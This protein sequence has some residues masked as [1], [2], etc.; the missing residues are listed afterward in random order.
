MPPAG[1][2]EGCAES[3][4][5]L[6]RFYRF[7]S[8]PLAVAQ[9]RRPE[10]PKR[11][12]DAGQPDGQ[13]HAAGHVCPAEHGREHLR[14]GPDRAGRHAQ[15][16]KPRWK[17]PGIRRESDRMPRVCGTRSRPSLRAIRTS[18]PAAKGAR[19]AAVAAAAYL[20]SSRTIASDP[21][22][23]VRHANDTAE[24]HRLGRHR[25][26]AG[27]DGHPRRDR[28][29]V[30]RWRCI[31]G[32]RGAVRC[33]A[34]SRLRVPVPVTISFGRDQRRCTHERENAIEICRSPEDVFGYL[35]RHRQGG[36]VEPEDQAGRE[37]H[38]GPG[39]GLPGHG[40]NQTPAQ[41]VTRPAVAVD[42]A[43]DAR[44]RR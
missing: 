8:L 42:A 2:R 10:R 35:T 29:S 43:N 34:V 21:S 26:S 15:P 19:S 11:K 36:R 9:C 37:A 3:S 20:P 31:S 39:T 16:R 13:Q 22:P 5:R 41:G 27:V 4:L 38:A 14:D 6:R 25:E 40:Q 33:S 17:R 12:G 18:A 7:C 24:R 1:Q 44:A 30:G 23:V 32:S 28:A